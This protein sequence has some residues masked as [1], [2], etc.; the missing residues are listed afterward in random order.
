MTNISLKTVIPNELENQ[1]K[2]SIY[3]RKYTFQLSN[4]NDNC[5][6]V[7]ASV[8]LE[9]KAHSAVFSTT[10]FFSS[11]LFKDAIIR[12][13]KGEEHHVKPEYIFKRVKELEG[14]SS[15]YKRFSTCMEPHSG[16]GVNTVDP[17]I[18]STTVLVPFFFSFQDSEYTFLK[19]RSTEKYFI[20]LYVADSLEDM[21]ISSLGPLPELTK[22]NVTMY[23][24]FH[25]TNLGPAKIPNTVIIPRF[26]CFYEDPVKLSVGDKKARL[27]LR[28]MFQLYSVSFMIKNDDDSE[29]VKIET[30]SI[31]LNGVYLIKK[32]P[33]M[34]NFTSQS[35]NRGYQ[36]TLYTY[37]FNKTNSRVEDS[38]LLTFGI[39]GGH[40]PVFAELEFQTLNQNSTLYTHCEYRT[41]IGDKIPEIRAQK[42]EGYT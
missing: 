26:N 41:N 8:Y 18:R 38:G 29:A 22:F 40:Y 27:L 35:I 28:C 24:T 36:D 16:F 9:T 1:E 3:G 12:S 10:S 7:E 20:D 11:Y 25:D 30:L 17:S 15:D 14:N 5:A 2:G 33:S 32:L 42:S 37:Y 4:V 13:S 6:Q 34:M 23:S 19:T 39:D 21:G 31:K